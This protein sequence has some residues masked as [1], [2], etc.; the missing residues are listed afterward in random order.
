MTEKVKIGIVGSS[1]WAELMFLN[2]LSSYPQAEI[3]AICG[4]NSS[5]VHD[6]ANK[7]IIPDTFTD[8]QA[9]IA[10]GKID[11]VVVATPDDLHYPVT[12]AALEARLHVLCE[13]Q[14]A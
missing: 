1:G 2:A 6:L 13:K 11:A 7:Y 9:M 12:M 14:L 3:V 10:S 4:R 8:Y 5:K